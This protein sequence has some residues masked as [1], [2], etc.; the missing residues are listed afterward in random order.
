MAELMLG[1][2]AAHFIGVE[3]CPMVVRVVIETLAE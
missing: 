1:V 2:Q 3:Q